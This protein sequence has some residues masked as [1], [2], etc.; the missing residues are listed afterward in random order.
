MKPVARATAVCCVAALTDAN[1][2][3]L[4]KVTRNNLRCKNPALNEAF[5]ATRLVRVS[6]WRYCERRP[7]HRRCETVSSVDDQPRRVKRA[8]SHLRLFCLI[9]A[10]K[11]VAVVWL[12]SSRLSACPEIQMNA[13]QVMT[14]RWMALCG[15]L[16]RRATS[17]PWRHGSFCAPLHQRTTAV[18]RRRLWSACRCVPGGNRR[19]ARQRRHYSSSFALGW[20]DSSQCG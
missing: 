3:N 12:H 2:Y 4:K 19:P 6:R 5:C 7:R 8:A 11:A 1:L 13:F 16:S 18:D 15:L 14:K 10:Q 17:A 20:R 9:S